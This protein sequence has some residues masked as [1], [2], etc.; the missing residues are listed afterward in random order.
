MMNNMN[1]HFLLGFLK[2]ANE[3]GL[4]ESTAIA[5]HEKYAGPAEDFK[6]IASPE[7]G[8]TL[9]GTT[10]TGT[11]TPG[12]MSTGASSVYKPALKPKLPAAQP[13]NTGTLSAPSEPGFFEKYFGVKPAGIPGAALGPAPQRKRLPA[14]TP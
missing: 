13:V 12:P 7:I 10:S 5:M 3:Y 9:P 14:G 11:L 1:K 6:N 4:D 8:V 2:R